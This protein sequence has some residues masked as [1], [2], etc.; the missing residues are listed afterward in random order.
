[1]NPVHPLPAPAQQAPGADGVCA[2]PSSLTGPARAAAPGA[3]VPRAKLTFYFPRDWSFERCFAHA[4]SMTT[5]LDCGVWSEFSA[6]AVEPSYRHSF[7][8]W[9]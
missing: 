5:R 6:A 7:C 2:H 4:V 1:M 8:A 9:L 3:F